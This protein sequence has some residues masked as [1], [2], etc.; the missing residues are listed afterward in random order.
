V[1]DLVPNGASRELASAAT[2]M[3]GTQIDRVCVFK[4]ITA[5]AIRAMLA[6]DKQKQMLGCS[7]A[8]CLSEIGGALGVD[9][10]VSGKVSL[11]ASLAVDF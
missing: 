1:L 4:V 10:L 11:L 9:Y 8:G 7:D 5:D 2:G 6:F 3:T